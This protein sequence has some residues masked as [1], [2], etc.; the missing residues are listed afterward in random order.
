M[1]H[2]IPSKLPRI[3]IVDDHPVCVD[4]IA[5]AA[6]QAVDDL[7]IEDARSMGE[8]LECLRVKRFDAVFLD[9]TLP[10][11]TGIEALEEIRAA[12]PDCPV[13]V[14]S[15]NLDPHMV[16]ET[17]GLG[18]R[19]YIPKSSSI[20]EIGRAVTVVLN[21]GVWFPDLS[22][23]LVPA[24]DTGP[25]SV[26]RLSKSQRRVLAAAA[27]GLDN[28]SIGTKLGIALP[29]VK[30]HMSECFRILGVRNRSEAILAFQSTGNS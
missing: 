10:D 22:T 26:A 14:I 16:R 11:A 2:N 20:D 7:G 25:E 21:G 12:Y 9:L 18:S 1:T 19:G 29:T 28:K 3:L 30:S 4:A 6:R 15:A 8:M 23:L 17:V 5:L 27:D 24:D 13:A